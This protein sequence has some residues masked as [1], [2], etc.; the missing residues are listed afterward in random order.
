[1]VTVR[2]RESAKRD[3][4]AQW[5]WYAENALFGEQPIQ[6]FQCLPVNPAAIRT[7]LTPRSSKLTRLLWDGVALAGSSVAAAKPWGCRAQLAPPGAGGWVTF[8][9]YTR[10]ITLRLRDI[11]DGL[12]EVIAPRLA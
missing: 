9:E 12:T 7:L 2:K 10:Q 5:V 11:T 6:P 3:L 1:M 8:G 4:I